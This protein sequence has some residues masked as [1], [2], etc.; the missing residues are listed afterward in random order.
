MEGAINEHKQTHTFECERRLDAALKAS[1]DTFEATTNLQTEWIERRLNAKLNAAVERESKNLQFAQ[2]DNLMKQEQKLQGQA[3]KLAKTYADSIEDRLHQKLD[4]AILAASL[5]THTEFEERFVGMTNKLKYDQVALKQD[6]RDDIQ[7]NAAKLETKF[8]SQLR[9]FQAASTTDNNNLNHQIAQ[10]NAATDRLN[11]RLSAV[12][13]QAAE[14]KDFTCNNTDTDGLTKKVLNR[15][16][17]VPVTSATIVDPVT[18]ITTTSY[19]YQHLSG[20]QIDVQS[21]GNTDSGDPAVLTALNQI[22]LGI[23]ALLRKQLTPSKLQRTADKT[24]TPVPSR[25]ITRRPAVP[26][27]I[28]RPPKRNA[29]LT[30][31]RD[32]AMKQIKDRATKHEKKLR[33]ENGRM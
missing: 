26:Q 32:A 22:N 2:Q 14:G 23:Q 5:H 8:Q 19:E 11:T 29:L 31:A 9:D 12:E 21:R 24:T 3:A 28:N 7:T 18:D 20:R 1:Q 13:N 16:T 17:S 6:L 10:L 4:S 25:R 15:V 33:S 27:K 30:T